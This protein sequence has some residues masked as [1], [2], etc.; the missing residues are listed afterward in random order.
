LIKKFRA[1]ERVGVEFRAEFFNVLNHPNFGLPFH[2]LY[3]G[4]VPQFG[5]VPTQ[6]ELDALPCNLTAAQAQTTSCN[7]RAGVISKTVGTPR[8]LQFGL[9]V[10]F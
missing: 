5:H 1:G 3:I 7:P 2:Q 8:Q 6:A 9:K 4:G 10:T